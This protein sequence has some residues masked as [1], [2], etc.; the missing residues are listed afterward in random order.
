VKNMSQ[1]RM[2][3]APS[4]TGVLHLGGART[5]LFNW[6]W[7]RHQGGK[8]LL[9]IEDTDK[10]R[11]TDEST[12]A[13]MDALIW[14]GL[15]WDEEPV[16]QSARLDEHRKSLQKLID[17]GSVYKCYCT[18]EEREEMRKNAL[19]KGLTAQYDG[20]CFGKPN[21][22]N[23]PFVWRFRMPKEG[24][25]VFDDLVMGRVATPN[26]ELEDLVIA[27]SDGSPLYNFVVVVDDAA[28]DI[29]HVIRGKDHLTNTPKQIQ[30]YKALD[31]KVPRFAHLPLILGLSKRLRSAGI[32]SYRGQGYLPE[33]VNNYIVRLGWSHGDREI[34]SPK[35][36]VELFKI[37]DVN[38]SEGAI[39][40]EKMEWI[41]QQHIQMCGPRRLALLTAPFLSDAGI[42]IDPEDQRLQAACES[43]RTKARTLKALAE[44]VRFYFVA[45]DALKYDDR[46]VKAHLTDK[47]RAWLGSVTGALSDTRDWSKESIGEVI[48]AFC[49]ANGLNLKQVAQPCRVALTGSQTGPGLFEM[50]SVLGRDATLNRLKKAAAGL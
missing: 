23:R 11:S 36:L 5:A 16:F 12:R 8:F 41:N 14:L 49:D 31:L 3:F 40:L 39:N 46:A 9:R 22:P 15:N 19:S 20:R 6:L 48:T 47:S 2:R 38:R 50:M 32:E 37:E 34:F 17:K 44:E 33:A 28:M 1:I 24:E 21:D 7:A 29:T 18:P 25:T 35:E 10:E 26:Q 30:L 42:E 27:R 45:D 4:P 13:I 43:R